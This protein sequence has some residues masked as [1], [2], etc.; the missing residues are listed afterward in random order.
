MSKYVVKCSCCVVVQNDNRE[1][2][3]ESYVSLRCT[4]C[5]TTH[6]SVVAKISSPGLSLFAN[7][8][9][10]TKANG[11]AI[12]A[13][14]ARF[15]ICYNDLVNRVHHL[16]LNWTFQFTPSVVPSGDLREIIYHGFP[17]LANLSFFFIHRSIS[18]CEHN[19]KQ[20]AYA[21]PW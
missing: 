10:P 12:A 21:L 9:I 6:V 17:V 13:I 16:R 15:R 8:C 7:H 4:G 3:R 19:A 5:P 1:K 18:L 11:G 20:S 14:Q 2:L